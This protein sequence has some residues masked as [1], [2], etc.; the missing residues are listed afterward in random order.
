[1]TSDEAG[2]TP[3]EWLTVNIGEGAYRFRTLSIKQ[4]FA[5]QAALRIMWRSLA[6]KSKEE[7][8]S[9]TA[10]ERSDVLEAQRVLFGT[11]CPL[12]I[13]PKQ[14]CEVEGC[15]DDSPH[16][17]FH[18]LTGENL[19]ELCRFYMKQNWKKLGEMLTV[20][21][22]GPKPSDP[23]E[24]EKTFRVVGRIVAKAYGNSFD[25]FINLRFEEAASRVIEISDSWDKENSK[26]K[27]TLEE[28]FDQM[29][30]QM[31]A[32]LTD[33]DAPVQVTDPADNIA[34]ATEPP[35]N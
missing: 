29:S 12:L 28:F 7:I 11:I 15:L 5:C 20:G 25:D 30:A 33:G 10:Q 21:E 2:L 13:Q 18:H 19:T 34:V 3:H 8:A 1:M 26:G 35:P 32:T 6:A 22:D 24:S 14:S 4:V 9:L 16:P 17:D 27:V 31:G 23:G